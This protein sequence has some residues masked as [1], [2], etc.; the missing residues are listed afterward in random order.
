MRRCNGRELQG[1]ESV[2]TTTTV[3]ATATESES[4]TKHKLENGRLSKA[5]HYLRWS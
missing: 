2:A 4:Q 3:T 5:P 1:P